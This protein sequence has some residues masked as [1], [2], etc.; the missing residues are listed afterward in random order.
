MT[1]LRVNPIRC[2]AHGLCAELLPELIHLDDWGYP[3][4]RV[5]AV[6][7][8]L[9]GLARRATSACPTLALLLDDGG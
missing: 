6:P 2:D 9:L 1:R 4:V 5:D 3:V 7:D 8:D